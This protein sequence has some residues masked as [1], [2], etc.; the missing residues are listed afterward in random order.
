V[1][2]PQLTTDNWPLTTKLV[3]REAE[4][5][6]LRRWLE[7]ALQGERQVVFVTG[8]PGI[9][10]TTVVEAFLL[11]VRD[12]GGRGWQCVDRPWPVH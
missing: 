10:K 11:G 4:L 9:G 2:G 1:S 12:W 3:G 6:Q 7:K 5:A 8:E